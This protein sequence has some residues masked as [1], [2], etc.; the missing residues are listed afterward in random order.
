MQKLEEEARLLDSAAKVSLR[1]RWRRSW[2]P[3]KVIELAR[4]YADNP[5]GLVGV[6]DEQ[7]AVNFLRHERTDYDRIV[8]RAAGIQHGRYE[9]YDSVFLVVKLRVHQR[10]AADFPWLEAESFAQYDEAES[11]SRQA[12]S[13]S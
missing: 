9:S 5:R 4:L 2:T 12:S 1:A 6:P 13:R 8:H 7:V 3:A 11:A 10:I